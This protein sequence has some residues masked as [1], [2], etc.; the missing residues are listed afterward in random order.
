MFG[1]LIYLYSFCIVAISLIAI[2][3]A[4]VLY[5]KKKKPGVVIQ[6][7][8]ARK[9]HEPGVSFVSNPLFQERNRYESRNF[10]ENGRYKI[11]LLIVDESSIL[12]L[13]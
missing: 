8:Q 3:A 7:S 10:T 12:W 6:R 2:I 5:R 1:M 13:L 11:K 9:M 4:V